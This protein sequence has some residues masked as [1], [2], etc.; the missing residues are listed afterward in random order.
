M[1]NFMDAVMQFT[2]VGSYGNLYMH[3]TITI[4]TL[5]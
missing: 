2:E 5:Q 1:Q 4:V 3:L